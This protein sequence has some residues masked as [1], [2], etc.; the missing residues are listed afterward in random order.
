MNRKGKPIQVVAGSLSKKVIDYNF[1]RV[2]SES[3]KA[4]GKKTASEKVASTVATFLNKPTPEAGLK[5][6]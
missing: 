1:M 6:H 4:R 2:F 3:V 5:G